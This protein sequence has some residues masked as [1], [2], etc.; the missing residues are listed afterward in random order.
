MGSESNEKDDDG[1]GKESK[2]KIKYEIPF[3]SRFDTCN[4][5]VYL[6][7]MCCIKWETI[8]FD[9]ILQIQLGHLENNYIL[10]ASINTATQYQILFSF[11]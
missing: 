8:D 4:F 10:I 3:S 9:I 7:L 5:I 11:L 1:E 2:L 6:S